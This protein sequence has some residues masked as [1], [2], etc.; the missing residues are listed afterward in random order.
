[1]RDAKAASIM[2]GF[3]AVNGLPSCADPFLLQTLLRDFWGFNE[4]RWVTADCDAIEFMFD[5]RHFVPDFAHAAATGMNAGAD[6]DCGTTYGDNLGAA[7]DMGLVNVSTIA[8]ALTRQYASF[9]R[10]VFSSSQ[11]RLS[12]QSSRR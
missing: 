11:I 2:C 5:Q 12:H 3:N 4:E 8:R 1:V 9:M 10:C 7:L 6:L